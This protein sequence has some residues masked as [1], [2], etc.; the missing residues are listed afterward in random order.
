MDAESEQQLK[1]KRLARS[2]VRGRD[3]LL[4]EQLL[5]L[6]LPRLVVRDAL[7]ALRRG[8]TH[9]RTSEQNERQ[10]SAKRHRVPAC[11]ARR[12][13]AR[14]IAPRQLAVT[15]RM[16]MGHAGAACSSFG[17]LAAPARSRHPALD[18]LPLLL[19][20]ARVRQTYS[21]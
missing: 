11:G 6:L 7:L 13:A 8:W 18:A 16:A 21:A 17:P 2:L 12:F 5:R 1:R 4:S 3:A 14:C 15:S 10:T 19:A 20:R 9:T